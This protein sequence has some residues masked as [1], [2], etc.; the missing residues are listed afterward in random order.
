[1]Q[2]PSVSVIMIVRNGERF[3]AAALASP[4][5][6]PMGDYNCLRTLR[7]SIARKRGE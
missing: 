5:N 1:M 6:D 4:L 7:A 3:I 2:V